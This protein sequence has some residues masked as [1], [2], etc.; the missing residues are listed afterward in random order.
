MFL[1]VRRKP[2]ETLQELGQSVRELTALAYQEFDE[3]GQ[4]RLARG[5]FMDAVTKP[6]ITEGLFRAQPRTLDEA[7]EAALGTEAFLKVE[8]D[9][10]DW[11]PAEIQQST[12]G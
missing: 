5:H 4:D 8:V 7:I 11:S 9:R 2:K 6:D 12:N 1:A 10:T 3:T